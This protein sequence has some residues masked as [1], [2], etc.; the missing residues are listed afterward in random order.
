[1]KEAYS[2]VQDAFQIPYDLSKSVTSLYEP[3]SHLFSV[4]PEFP[5]NSPIF[6]SG[7]PY[8]V[9]IGDSIIPGIT[10]TDITI[11]QTFTYIFQEIA[12]SFSEKNCSE[13]PGE[14][15][16]IIHFAIQVV[17]QELLKF[18]SFIGKDVLENYVAILNQY[19]EL[20]SMQDQDQTIKQLR[21]QV[22]QICTNLQTFFNSI[23]NKRVM[24]VSAQYNGITDIVQ[25]FLLLFQTFGF[26]ETFTGSLR[27]FNQIDIEVFNSVLQLVIS[28]S[29]STQSM[30]DNIKTEISQ[31]K[32]MIT[33]ASFCYIRTDLI[34]SIIGCLDEIENM[35]KSQK[36]AAQQGITITQQMKRFEFP[37]E[38]NFP[39]EYAQLLLQILEAFIQGN[40]SAQ[41]DTI[42][43]AA[44]AIMNTTPNKLLQFACNYAIQNTEASFCDILLIYSLLPYSL[45]KGIQHFCSVAM[46]MNTYTSYA[47]S[48][49]GA[50]QV[51]TYKE[52]LN[53][54]SKIDENEHKE[55]SIVNAAW[56]IILARS[57]KTYATTLISAAEPALQPADKTPDAIFS[58]LISFDPLVLSINKYIEAL[59]PAKKTTVLLS[60][61]GIPDFVSSS[62]QL[63]SFISP[64][65]DI[66]AGIN[67][68][69]S[70]LGKHISVCAKTLIQMLNSLPGD[71]EIQS[72]KVFAFS[73]AVE[74]LAFSK[75]LKKDVKATVDLC[76]L[77]C[78]TEDQSKCKECATSLCSKLND[79]VVSDVLTIPQIL[80]LNDSMI[81]TE[82]RKLIPSIGSLVPNQAARVCEIASQLNS[83]TISAAEA[84]NILTRINTIATISD[85]LQQYVMQL[86]VTL[87]SKANV[88]QEI[89]IISQRFGI[90]FVKSPPTLDPRTAS[91]F[92]LITLFGVAI[93]KDVGS[94]AQMLEQFKRDKTEKSALQAVTS[95]VAIA[96]ANGTFSNTI[97][98][99][100][101]SIMQLVYKYRSNQS[102]EAFNNLVAGISA[103]QNINE[104]QQGYADQMWC[105]ILLILSR[106]AGLYPNQRVLET[107]L[108][109]QDFTIEKL[110]IPV[111]ETPKVQIIE[112]QPQKPSVQ[113]IEPSQ[114][115]TV[116]KP[117]PQANVI[118]AETK[119]QAEIPRFT[120]IK[121]EENVQA[122]AP[123]TNSPARAVPSASIPPPPPPPPPP[124]TKKET[125]KPESPG[126]QLQQPLAN[127]EKSIPQSA[128]TEKQKVNTKISLRS[129][130]QVES[131]R[132]VCAALADLSQ[133]DSGNLEL[134]VFNTS[135]NTLVDSITGSAG[136][137]YVQ[138]TEKVNSLSQ[139]VNSLFAKGTKNF[140]EQSQAF[141][142]I[143]NDIVNQLLKD[144][145][146]ANSAQAE[147]ILMTAKVDALQSQV[148][149]VDEEESTPLRKIVG[150][151]AKALLKL[152]RTLG[153]AAREQ[154]EYLA[155]GN[156]SITNEKRLINAAQ[157]TTDAA[158]MFFMLLKST[159]PDDQDFMFKVVAASHSMNSALTSLIINFRA[160]G[161]SYEITQRMEATVKIIS[162]KMQ[163]LI[164]KAESYY[165]ADHDESLP[166]QKEKMSAH[167]LKVARMN[168][169]NEII[170]RRRE[171]EEAEDE[172]KRF[173]RA[174]SSK[175][176]AQKP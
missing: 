6:F 151:E 74:L 23:T 30:F 116:T 66:V 13:F 168:A 152:T 84:R 28:P 95:I 165:G 49:C 17:A 110:F 163:E 54:L 108:S 88:L 129:V 175:S 136:D 11:C 63:Q 153:K 109:I 113:I 57:I 31:Y 16:E 167:N 92:N 64:I 133:S 170:K 20:F 62:Q 135:I 160:L 76:S 19:S 69:E 18:S 147:I 21:T 130:R 127:L 161:G 58:Q 128:E 107:Y 173:N 2:G 60:S 56:L 37:E 114:E 148:A 102:S 97:K 44:T 68:S 59:D 80:A 105:S 79:F 106:T 119:Q 65:D 45:A 52:F 112:P 140:E 82:A 25:K 55:L 142:K 156:G 51:S 78:S 139:E 75:S 131:A 104:P 123:V 14:E 50:G 1:M 8:S 3:I 134:E 117:Q 61:L 24:P 121:S 141:V 115:I 22:D 41:K 94:V 47:I 158:Q 137:L 176:R 172:L 77:F 9:M 103:A 169:S 42:K 10:S 86:A 99:N 46:V 91:I 15:R 174:A 96:T 126:K 124:P 122:K 43:Q 89:D 166:E 5:E 150:S 33:G 90:N 83:P 98:V 70:E 171:L 81:V 100:V 27:T 36:P 125:K 164:E 157:Q 159:K 7:I 26:F 149:S 132:C 38:I 71:Y 32:D 143:T 146:L 144:F 53:S 34:N 155:R 67:V 111:V 72:A 93:A 35:M 40:G 154:A 118:K 39:D 162:K 120:E 73:F 145:G 101:V 29:A 4:D 48:Q 87:G 138:I 85:P 12:K